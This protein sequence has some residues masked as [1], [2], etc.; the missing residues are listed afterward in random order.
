MRRRLALHVGL[1]VGL[2]WRKAFLR[3]ALLDMTLLELTLRLLRLL[4]RRR[5]LVT[6]SL[7]RLALETLSRLAEFV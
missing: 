7:F 4:R 3:R 5:L 6:C 1:Q 2:L